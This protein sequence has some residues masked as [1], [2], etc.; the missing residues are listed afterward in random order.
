MKRSEVN[1]ILLE[2]AGR[3]AGHSFHSPITNFFAHLQK[4]YGLVLIHP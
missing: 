1:T 2:A 3:T 4:L